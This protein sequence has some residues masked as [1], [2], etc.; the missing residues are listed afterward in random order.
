[1]YN[2]YIEIY[3]D[4]YNLTVEKSND[5]PGENYILE[6][7]NVVGFFKDNDKIVEFKKGNSKYRK[8]DLMLF[9]IEKDK[10]H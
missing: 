8:G 7:G 4:H 1:M 2:Q 5:I 10:A 9:L 6:A 3:C